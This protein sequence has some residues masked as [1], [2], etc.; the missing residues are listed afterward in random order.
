MIAPH[1]N[2]ENTRSRSFYHF[3]SSIKKVI[4]EYKSENDIVE[5]QHLDFEIS[6]TDIYQDVNL[7]DKE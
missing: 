3:I 7:E 1:L 4:Q 2:L 5:L 6:L